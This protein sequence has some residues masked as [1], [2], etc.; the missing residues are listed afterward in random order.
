MPKFQIEAKLIV[1]RLNDLHFDLY[2]PC[3]LASKKVDIFKNLNDRWKLIS[4]DENISTWGEK[5]IIALSQIKEE[6]IF[7]CLDDF[8]PY[9]R[10]SPRK[11]KKSLEEAITFK[12]SIIRTNNN[13]NQRIR[14][15][16][17]TDSIFKESYL[18]KYGK[19][20]VFQIF[21]KLF[22]SQ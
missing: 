9:L 7:I 22:Y 16:Q 21:K 18:H 12:P 15:K 4:I 1:K 3:F 8:Y 17:L 14:L 2:F 5:M 6:Y 10:I 11:L 13:F 19:S 20:L